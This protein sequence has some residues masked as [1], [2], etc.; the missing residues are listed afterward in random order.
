[1]KNLYR[2]VA[3]A[4]VCTALGF[5][6]GTSEEVK[7]ATFTLTPTIQFGA[8]ASLYQMGVYEDVRLIP[9][10]EHVS[11]GPG[12]VTARF[13]EFNISNFFLA[14]NT[15]IRSAIFQDKISSFQGGRP[16]TLG[17]FG[18]LGNGTAEASD[19]LGDEVL[20]TS[21][22]ISSSSPGDTLNFDQKNGRVRVEYITVP[23]SPKNVA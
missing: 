3:V 14:P 9:G 5:V 2:K 18:Y 1:M 11:Y 10:D 4:S 17:I 13:A 16:G 6:L 20:L 15:I 22:D 8:T 7:A 19:L 23:L 21:V 12:S